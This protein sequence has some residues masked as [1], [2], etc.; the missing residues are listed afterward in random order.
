MSKDVPK[1]VYIDQKWDKLID[2]SLRRVV[3]G[4]LF[5]SAAALLIFSEYCRASQ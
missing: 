2:L 4:T 1:E 5:G 3:Y